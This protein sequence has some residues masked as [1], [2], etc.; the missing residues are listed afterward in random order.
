MI[1]INIPGPLNTL[2]QTM[3]GKTLLY[4]G[5]TEDALGS[6]NELVFHLI[7]S[8][9]IPVLLSKTVLGPVSCAPRSVKGKH[10]YSIPAYDLHFKLTMINVSLIEN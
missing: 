2:Q 4:E 7:K 6:V 3:T 10:Y 9:S 5:G 1:S 8:L